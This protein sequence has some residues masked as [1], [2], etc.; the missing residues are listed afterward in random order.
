[1][2]DVY[3]SGTEYLEVENQFA[4]S[5]DTYKHYINI[6]SLCVWFKQTLKVVLVNLKMLC[7]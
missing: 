5:A 7:D 2:G 3:I 1:M 6:S 4:K